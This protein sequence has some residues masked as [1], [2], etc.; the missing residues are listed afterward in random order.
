MMN[1]GFLKGG[2]PMRRRSSRASAYALIEMLV[3]IV[4]APFLMVAVSGFFRSFVRDIPQATR[5]VQQNTTV[6]NL[7]DQLRR[8]VDRAVALPERIGDAQANDSTLLIEQP[9][10]VVWYRF[11][12]GQ[13]V[14]RL[15]DRQGGTVPDEDRVWQARDAVIEWRPWLRE[16]RAYALEVHSH[17]KQRV[18]GMERRKLAGTQVFFMGGLAGGEVR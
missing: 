18:A 15:L 5:L 17:L 9:D 3:L 11:D 10:V 13:I 4:I 7:L 1:H 2:G 6:L 14:R 12:E 8:D 16:S